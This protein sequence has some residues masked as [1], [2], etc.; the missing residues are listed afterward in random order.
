MKRLQNT[1]SRLEPQ[2]EVTVRNEGEAYF[3]RVFR[4]QRYQQLKELGYQ[5]DR[6][7]Q[8]ALNEETGR[9]EMVYIVEWQE[10]EEPKKVTLN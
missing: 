2:A 1:R 8:L 5:V 4:D 6:Y 7:A 3:S 9:N 10:E